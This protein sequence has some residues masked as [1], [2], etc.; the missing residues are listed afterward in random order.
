M[1]F[2]QRNK[3][4]VAVGTRSR[5]FGFIRKLEIERAMTLTVLCRELQI[6][7]SGE[8]P[9][10]GGKLSSCCISAKA[11]TWRGF[12]FPLNPSCQLSPLY[13]L[14]SMHNDPCGADGLP[15]PDR[16]LPSTSSRA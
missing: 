1:L 8:A 4:D 5:G 14:Q 11:L 13:A 9:P 12:S 7:F 16:S 2:H 10:V 6:D 15:A 3:K